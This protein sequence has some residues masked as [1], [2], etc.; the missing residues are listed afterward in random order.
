M[1]ALEQP[2]R[3]HGHGLLSV[4]Q[5]VS[6]LLIMQNQNNS[7]PEKIADFNNQLLV[8]FSRKLKIDIS[9]II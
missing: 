9:N 4:L 6:C 8:S 2:Q 5:R 1:E 3:A 7:D